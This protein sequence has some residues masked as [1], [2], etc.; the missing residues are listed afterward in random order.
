MNYFYVWKS[1][2]FIQVC[3]AKKWYVCSEHEGAIWTNTHTRA[4]EKQS[5]CEYLLACWSVYEELVFMR[6]CDSKKVKIYSCTLARINQ[7]IKYIFKK[8]KKS[9]RQKFF[10]FSFRLMWK[11]KNTLW[12]PAYWSVWLTISANFRYVSRLMTEPLGGTKLQNL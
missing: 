1:F 3:L 11:S 6:I 5:V 4:L 12:L 2:V 10:S 8:K 7:Y 9:Y